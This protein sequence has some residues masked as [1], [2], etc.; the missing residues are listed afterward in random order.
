M[1]LHSQTRTHIH[2]HMH[3]CCHTHSDNILIHTLTH[4][5]KRVCAHTHSH[6]YYMK[7]KIKRLG[8]MKG[9]DGRRK[10]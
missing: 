1:Y 7:V 2:S 3:I 4:I 6:V 10:G 9:T 8:V 5:H